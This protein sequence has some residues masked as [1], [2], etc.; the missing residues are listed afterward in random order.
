MDNHAQT[1]LTL[2]AQHNGPWFN[3]GAKTL[4]KI[5]QNKR[6]EFSLD[7]AISYLSRYVVLP[8][9]KTYVYE[10]CSMTD[11]VRSMFPKAMR[12]AIAEELA[13]ELI[14]EFRLGTFY[15]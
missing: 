6:K 3:D 13:R 2:Y 1:E 12:D 11:S 9:A 5:Y 10:N 14:S 15:K 7:R 4:S 8:A